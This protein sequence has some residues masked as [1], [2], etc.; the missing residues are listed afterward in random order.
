MVCFAVASPL[1]IM[2]RGNVVSFFDMASPHVIM[3][4]GIVVHFA[5]ASPLRF[6]QLSRVR[7]SWY[8]CKV[9]CILM[10]FSVLCA[11]AFDEAKTELYEF[12]TKDHTLYAL[13]WRLWFYYFIPQIMVDPMA[14]SLW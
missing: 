11:A 13:S 1:V 14:T 9:L 2:Q 4:R 12:L 8:V 10:L 7:I 5:M 3:Q 6:A